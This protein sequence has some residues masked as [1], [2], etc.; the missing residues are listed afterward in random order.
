MEGTQFKGYIRKY[1]VFSFV[2]DADPAENH[3]TYTKAN[4]SLG[5][6]QGWGTTGAGGRARL[7]VCYRN[8]N[9]GFAV[10]WNTGRFKEVNTLET[11]KSMYSSRRA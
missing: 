11:F 4:G 3:L 9:L 5:V 2:E 1:R 10:R 6:E 7:T 8:G